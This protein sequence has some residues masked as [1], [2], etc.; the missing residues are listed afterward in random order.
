MAYFRRQYLFLM[1]QKSTMVTFCFLFLLISANFMR[2]LLE[3]KGADVLMMVQPMR[4]MLLSGERLMVGTRESLMLIQIYP[5]LV[6]FPAGLMFA[7]D[8]SNHM[9]TV[10]TTRIGK[11]GYIR[12]GLLAVFFCT[13][14]VFTVPFAV[15]L[16][17]YSVSFPLKAAGN[18]YNLSLYDPA[19]AALISAYPNAAFMIRHPILY[20]FFH[21]CFFGFVSA[22][23]ATAVAALSYIWR[24]RYRALYLLVPVIL[25]YG[26]LYITPRLLQGAEDAKAFEWYAFLFSYYERT[27]YWS[28]F[29]F[30]LLLVLVLVLALYCWGVRSRA[31]HE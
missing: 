10:I 8:R 13:F 1:K 2:N 7:A 14:T 5:F 23:L 20:T 17:L 31:V 15:E 21:I 18:L 27:A 4:L 22:L 11:R 30:C 6:A 9:Q 29:L 26:N 12:G 24:F 19:Y 16:L 3:N 25:L 28:V